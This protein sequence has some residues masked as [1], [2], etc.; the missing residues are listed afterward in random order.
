MKV[1]F[2]KKE[3]TV[4]ELEHLF[5]HLKGAEFGLAEVEESS[6]QVELSGQSAV[7]GSVAIVA[8]PS[9]KQAD[10]LAVVAEFGRMGRDTNGHGWELSSSATQ[11]KQPLLLPFQPSKNSS[12][13]S[14]A[15]PIVIST[16][17]GRTSV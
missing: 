3:Q 10:L 14:G 11:Q 16:R 9:E 7:A 6:V 2:G 13:G 1:E 12:H 17:A 15:M 8:L 5:E 4:A